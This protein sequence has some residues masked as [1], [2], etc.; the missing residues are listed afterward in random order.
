L[1]KDIYSISWRRFC[2]LIANLSQNSALV[3]SLVEEHKNEN[4]I[5]KDPAEAEKAVERVWG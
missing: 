3:Q 5:I 1:S 4:K 2:V